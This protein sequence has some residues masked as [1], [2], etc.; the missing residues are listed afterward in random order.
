MIIPCGKNLGLCLLLKL[1]KTKNLHRCI[2]AYVSGMLPNAA[3]QKLYFQK[4][5]NLL[6]ILFNNSCNLLF[7]TDDARKTRHVD[8]IIKTNNRIGF[9]GSTPFT[10]CFVKAGLVSFRTLLTCF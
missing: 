2:Y 10:P 8:K 9:F 1:R 4:I 7:K 5:K 3:T 6:F